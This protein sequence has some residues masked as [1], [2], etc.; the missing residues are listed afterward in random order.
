MVLSSNKMVDVYL[1]IEIRSYNQDLKDKAENADKI[2]KKL[3][4]SSDRSHKDSNQTSTTENKERTHM[5]TSGTSLDKN[6]GGG[7]INSVA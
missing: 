4:I 2:R 1:I 7:E 5:A 3:Q 6:C